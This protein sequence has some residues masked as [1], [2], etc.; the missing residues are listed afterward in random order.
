MVKEI[1]GRPYIPCMSSIPCIMAAI[2]YYQEEHY[3][4]CY[5]DILDIFRNEVLKHSN[6]QNV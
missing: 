2:N 4:I 5:R 1:Q 3:A 6:M